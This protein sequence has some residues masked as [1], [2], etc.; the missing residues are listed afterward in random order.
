MIRDHLSGHTLCLL[1]R[2]QRLT[3]HLGSQ[4]GAGVFCSG[5]WAGWG[6]VNWLTPE[7]AE[8]QDQG[9]GSGQLVRLPTH[10]ARTGTKKS[11]PSQREA[12][13]PSTHAAPPAASSLTVSPQLGLPID[14]GPSCFGAFV[15]FDFSAILQVTWNKGHFLHKSALGLQSQTT[16]SLP[17]P[18]FSKLMFHKVR[19]RTPRGHR[20]DTGRFQQLRARTQYQTSHPVFLLY[21][22]NLTQC[23][24]PGWPGRGWSC[25]QGQGRG[26]TQCDQKRKGL[27]HSYPRGTMNRAR[28]GCGTLGQTLSSTIRAGRARSPHPTA[29]FHRWFPFPE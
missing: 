8:A 18:S 15:H 13:S 3:A 26:G 29:P 17:S 10:L 12:C 19:S 27:S 7:C 1:G 23:L 16:T 28:E 22:R 21:P 5:D 9:P 14:H 24:V 4:Y 20:S 11:T 6:W 2:A 25:P